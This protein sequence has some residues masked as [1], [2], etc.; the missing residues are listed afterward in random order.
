MNAQFLYL[1]EPLTLTFESEVQEQLR[2]P[3]GRL[4]VI[5]N[6][7][8][9]YPTG[10]GQAHDTGT[11]GNARVV[12][13]IKSEDGESVIH[14]LDNE[15]G[16]GKLKAAIDRERRIRHMQHHTAQHL[17]SGCF[18]Q[19]FDLETLSSS[20]NGYEPTTI[21][22]PDRELNRDN[23]DS[24][25]ELAN[26]IVYE[27]R[28]VK[29]YFVPAARIH[30][31]PLRRPPKVDG[32][33][34]IVEIDRFDYSACGATHCPQTGMIGAIKIIRTERINQKTRVHFVAGIQAISYFRQYQQIATSLA[35]AFSTHPSEVVALVNKQ[36]AQLHSAEKELSQLRQATNAI[37][38]QQMLTNAL[39]IGERKIILKTFENR[40]V[41]E[42][43]AL[44]NQFKEQTDLVSLLANY[45]GAKIVL[46]ATCGFQTNLSARELLNQQLT[47]I[48]GRGGGDDQIAQG[49]GTATREQFTEFFEQTLDL[50]KSTGS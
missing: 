25:E 30:E 14:I 47:R 40:P 45:D 26:Q 41:S 12:D 36:S 2:L 34:R 16:S 8:Y 33:I 43:R 46:V 50:F 18:Q 37:E 27:N 22:L 4:G 1:S 38:A 35:A 17:L 6:Q 24:I 49:G 42:I 29:S 9:F 32:E 31:V 11:L 23:L 7:T 3:D 48:N 5:L 28:V 10:G 21:D 13:V 39:T 19:R 44:G 15:P 20:I